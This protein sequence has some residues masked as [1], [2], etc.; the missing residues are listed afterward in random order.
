MAIG[1][2]YFSWVS[3]WDDGCGGEQW[4]LTIN[5]DAPSNAVA[6][7]TIATYNP[8]DGGSYGQGL[9]T[10]YVQNGWPHDVSSDNDP[11]LYVNG[12]T[13]FTFEANVLQGFV[14]CTANV[15]VYD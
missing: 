9:V 12:A 11:L 7:I 13:S 2:L 5:L 1:G 14:D 10:G 3:A 8:N 15:F 6:E 4:F